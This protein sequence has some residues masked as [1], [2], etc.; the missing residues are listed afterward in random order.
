MRLSGKHRATVIKNL[1]LLWLF[2]KR[3]VYMSD[4]D[5]VTD[6]NLTQGNPAPMDHEPLS[7][8]PPLNTRPPEPPNRKKTLLIVAA[9]L[10]TLL[11]GGLATYFLMKDTND[12]ANDGDTKT[13]KVIKIG[14]IGPLS[15]ETAGLG[16]SAKQGVELAMKEFNK[17]GVTIQLV[18]KD[19]G[20]SAEKSG[21]AAKEMIEKDKVIAIIGDVC[22]GATLEAAKEA[23]KARIPLISG[24]STSPK[25]SESGDYIFRTV[26]SDDLQGEFIAKDMRANNFSKLAIIYGNEPYGIGL[27]T[28]LKASFEKLS[29]SVVASETF[30]NGAINFDSQLK[31]IKAAKPDVV[32]IISNSPTSAVALILSV[33]SSGLAAKVY[34]SESIKIDSI[35]SDAGSAA[36]GIQVGALSEGT[37][38][39][40]EKYET[41]FGIKPNFPAAQ[42][43]DAFKAIAKALEGG[44]TTSEDIK[45]SLY[46]TDFEAASG[47]IKFDE[48][49][50]VDAN[51]LLYIV[52]D[53]QFVLVR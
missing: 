30:E 32:Y 19:T 21:P 34:G 33:Q 18:V 46:S 35:L 36:E 3:W 20:C 39:F 5:N 14:L 11:L 12:Q 23:E 2:L 45:T 38:S 6:N 26:P 42:S 44:A 53:K 41:L 17:A 48:N 40:T 47:R 16:T 10:V 28:A 9:A 8:T 22:S 1:Y 27:N 37:T 4:Q 31:N 52:K 25:I 7:P 51:Y 29:G 49:G 24:A 15:G 43:Y 50:D 13:Q